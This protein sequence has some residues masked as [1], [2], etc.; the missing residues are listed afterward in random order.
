MPTLFHRVKRIDSHLSY[1]LH[2][3]FDLTSEMSD[4]LRERQAVDHLDRQTEVR[5]WDRKPDGGGKDGR[6][7]ENSS[8]SWICVQITG[9]AR[10][11]LCEIMLIYLY[12]MQAVATQPF[13]LSHR[14]GGDLSHKK[15]L[16]NNATQWKDVGRR[17]SS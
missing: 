13:F 6:E 2:C 11:N 10:G 7:E 14:G 12:N 15:M 16:R 17:L 4:C 9:W 3:D 5:L 8:H 1:F